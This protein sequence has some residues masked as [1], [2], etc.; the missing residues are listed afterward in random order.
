VEGGLAI[1]GAQGETLREQLAQVS[2]QQ[3]DQ[4]V[5]QITAQLVKGLDL[6]SSEIVGLET[7]G[8]SLQLDFMGTI[9]GYVQR[10]GDKYGARLRLPEL[11]LA[12]GLGAAE[13]ELPFA[14]R[15]TLRMRVHAQLDTNESW[16]LEYGPTDSHQ[17]M[18]G[19]LYDFKVASDEF[20]LS[21]DRTL[22]M[23][24]LVVEAAD[25][26]AF[27]ETLRGY[28]NQAS[29]AVRL[30]P[31]IQ[32]LPPE[33]LP[34]EMEGEGSVDEVMEEPVLEPVEPQPERPDEPQR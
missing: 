14:F 4:A 31:N 26:P 19:F 15:D 20:H 2:P 1:T 22:T 17:E 16:I 12:D 18:E 32:E 10:N 11:G 9:P 6:T 29:R 30:V 27:L 21:V 34:Q 3:R 5:R 7:A 33:E 23:R 24:G 25:F 8:A 28:E 13:R